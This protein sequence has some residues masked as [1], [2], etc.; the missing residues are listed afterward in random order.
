V[1]SVSENALM[2]S[3]AALCPG[4]IPLQPERVPR[5]LRDLGAWPVGAAEWSAEIFEELRAVGE[6]GAWRAFN[7]I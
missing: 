4:C 6:H 2:H 7:S 5:A 3:Y 1:K